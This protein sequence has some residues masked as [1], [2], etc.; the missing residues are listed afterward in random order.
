MGVMHPGLAFLGVESFTLL[1]NFCF[2]D[3][4]FCSRYAEKPSKGSKDSDGSQVSNKTLSQKMD[5][6]I[7]AKHRTKLA[8][9]T[10]EQPHL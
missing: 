8:K 1:T 7:G 4:S 9:K 2:L 6:Q 3:H 5:Y 10:Q